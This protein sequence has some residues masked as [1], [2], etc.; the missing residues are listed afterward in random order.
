[1]ASKF[2]CWILLLQDTI[3]TA[4]NVA[5]IILVLLKTFVIFIHNDEL[6]YL[7]NYAKTN[8]WHSNY[9]SHEQMIIN[10]SKRICTFLVCSFA[11]FAQGTVASFILRPILGETFT[12]S[13][14]EKYE[15][16]SVQI[17]T[18]TRNIFLRNYFVDI[19]IISNWNYNN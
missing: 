15:N 6:L 16:F 9:D 8:F 3:Y 13:I 2:D 10:T 11:F 18:L 14:C 19:V 4:C 17:K 5:T 12:Q 7:I 1:M